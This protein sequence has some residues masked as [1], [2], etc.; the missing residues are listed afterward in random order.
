MSRLATHDFENSEALACM[1]KRGA[2]KRSCQYEAKQKSEWKKIIK[3]KPLNDVKLKPF[4]DK[5]YEFNGK[6]M[7]NGQPLTW[8]EW[9]MAMHT[10]EQHNKLPKEPPSF[11]PSN[12]PIK[13]MTKKDGT[14]YASLE[15][16]QHPT[17]NMSY[18]SSDDDY[19]AT[20]G[21]DEEEEYEEPLF[22]FSGPHATIKKRGNIKLD[23]GGIEYLE[24]LKMSDSLKGEIMGKSFQLSG[25]YKAW[26]KEMKGKVSAEIAGLKGSK[27]VACKSKCHV[28]TL[29]KLVH[30][31]IDSTAYVLRCLG[32]SML[33]VK[34]KKPKLKISCSD[35]KKITGKWKDTTGWVDAKLFK[36]DDFG[37]SQGK[38]IMGFGPSA[39][40]K[41]F[42]AERIVPMLIEAKAGYPKRFLSID[43]GTYRE[44]S[45]V[46][47]TIKTAALM[48]QGKTGG[49]TNLVAAGVSLSG[50]MFKA[51]DVKK[52]VFEWLEG[53]KSNVANLYI[54]DTLGSSSTKWHKYMIYTKSK[55][56][57]VGLCIYMHKHGGNKC[58]YM[59]KFRCEGCTESGTRRQGSEGK[60]YSNTAYGTT[61]S[62]GKTQA[63]KAT[64]GY[65]LIHNTG[66]NKLSEQWCHSTIQLGGKLASGKAKSAIESFQKEYNF[67]VVDNLED[68]A[69]T[70]SRKRSNTAFCPEAPPLKF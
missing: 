15:M 45:D 11:G 34:R 51:G 54:P 38:L 6:Y 17:L 21:C 40:G 44:V 4:A 68:K 20:S 57:W 30:E 41:T 49:L 37:Q 28:K 12:K 31:E 22:E 66:L 24:A 14:K 8:N 13:I 48:K 33:T 5:Y 16:P 46:Y 42:W 9:S 2:K 7:L 64:G 36:L 59:P 19:H 53:Q 65:M 39:A 26:K 70:S 50:G 25:G 43:G 1:L 61:L 67:R 23:K 47:Q 56:Y 52:A 69:L 10:L 32:E 55:S 35:A 58:P 27:W 62:R 3:K 29:K 18:E 63:K 60:K